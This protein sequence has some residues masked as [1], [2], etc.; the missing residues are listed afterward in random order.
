MQEY[1]FAYDAVIAPGRVVFDVRNDGRLQ[2]RL[3]LL[4]LPDDLPPIDVQVHGSQ[5]RVVSPYAGVPDR[6]PGQ[7]GVFAADLVAGRRYG[8][9]CFLVDA[10]GATHAFKGMTAEFRVT[11]A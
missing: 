4:P 1:R 11:G 9:V 2:H 10:D 3:A 7:R 5:H 8:L 6:R